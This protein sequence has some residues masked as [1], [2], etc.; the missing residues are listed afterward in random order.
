MTARSKE[1]IALKTELSDRE[2]F[3]L[4]S[5]IE[6]RKKSVSLTYVLWFFLSFLGIHKFYLGRIWAGILYVIGPSI[7]A[8][9][10]LF[11][12]LVMSFDPTCQASPRPKNYTE[13][14][15][16]LAALGFMGLIAYGIWW[17][18]DLFTIPNQ[19]DKYNEGIEIETIKS[20]QKG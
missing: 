18:I 2:F 4:Q 6:R 11:T 12:G 7:A 17:F 13:G 5:E 19:V 9:I 1:L 8:S 15:F 10:F 14:E 16:I 3:I 20:F